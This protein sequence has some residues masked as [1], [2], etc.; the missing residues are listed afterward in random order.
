M[1]NINLTI[2]IPVYNRETFLPR[3][4]H[5]IAAQTCRAF[6]LIL[7]DNGSTDGSLKV[8][9]T[10]QYQQN[11]I[12]DEQV[13]V[14]VEEHPGAACARNRG[15][16]LCTTPYIYFFDSDD[17]MSPDFVET[18]LPEL[19]TGPDVLALTTLLI[20]R[21]VE[22]VRAFSRRNNPAV[23]ILNSMLST[24]SMVMRTDFLRSIGGWNE[25]LRTW[26]DWELGI[27][28]LAAHPR[29]TWYTRR[30]FHRIYLHAES[31]T[32][33]GFSATWPWIRRALEVAWIDVHRLP[34]C[35]KERSQAETALYYRQAIL[36]GQLQAEGNFAAADECRHLQQEINGLSACKQRIAK[37]LCTYTARGG[38]GSWWLALHLL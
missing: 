10:F 11:T 4:L 5:S 15:L 38:R 18:I 17:E 36:C 2:V 30:P 23:H 25:A 16:V 27:R 35:T 12:S 31:Q 33:T 9:K 20:D 28:V 19:E 7:V 34:T 37:C 8:C 14:T 29:L 26:D 22:H 6:R 21:Q 24:V 3:T 32:G 1:E 13:V